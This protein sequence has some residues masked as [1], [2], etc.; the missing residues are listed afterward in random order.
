MYRKLSKYFPYAVTRMSFDGCYYGSITKVNI[1]ITN[2]RTLASGRVHLITF[3]DV[4][5]IVQI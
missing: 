5:I 3:M 1:A 2:F 4:R